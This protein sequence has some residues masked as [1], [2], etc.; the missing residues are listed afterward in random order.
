MN[1]GQLRRAPA[2]VCGKRLAKGDPQ[3]ELGLLPPSAVRQC[4]N[5][6]QPAAEQRDCFFGSRAPPGLAPSGKPICDRL[7]GQ[8]GFRAV[9]SEQISVI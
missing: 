4:G 1:L 2:P 9:V 6:S 5:Q 3:I 7:L 8:T